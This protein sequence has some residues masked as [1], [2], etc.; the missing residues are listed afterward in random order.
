MIVFRTDTRLSVKR[1]IT[2]CGTTSAFTSLLTFLLWCLFVFA[3]NHHKVA[4]LV[5]HTTVTCPWRWQGP[6]RVHLYFCEAGVVSWNV[7]IGLHRVDLKLIQVIEENT[8]AFPLASEHV[9]V[10]VDDAGSVAVT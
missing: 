2:T 4:I 9:N 6:V 3:S 7:V 1:N 5:A 8:F 10:V